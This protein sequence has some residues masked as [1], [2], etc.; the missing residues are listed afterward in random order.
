[1]DVAGN[2]KFCTMNMG[3]LVILAGFSMA[4]EAME[5]LSELMASLTSYWRRGGN[6]HGVNTGKGQDRAEDKM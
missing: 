1:M 6:P 5:A 2:E 4:S 3:T